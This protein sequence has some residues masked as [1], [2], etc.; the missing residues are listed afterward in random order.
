MSVAIA[1]LVYVASFYLIRLFY[2]VSLHHLD[3]YIGAMLFVIPGFPFITSGLDISKLD[4]RSGLERMAYAIMI[5]VVATAVGWVM[6]L[7]L[8]LH[9][10]NF[11]NLGLTPVVLTLL[12]LLASFCG[13]FG[14]SIMFNSKISMATIAG[15]SGAIANTL[16]LSLVDW[17]NVPPAVAAFIGAFVAGMLASIIRRKIGFPRIAI[18]VPSIVI[19][20]PG[21]YMYRAMFNLGLTSLNAGALW[22]VQ[23]LMIVICLP[24]G[25][26]AARILM[27][28]DWRHAG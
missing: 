17:S 27:D 20:V 16:R 23:A 12:R 13:V 24:L 5:I 25:L 11:E 14:F 15:I 1:C 2:P 18:T 22:M 6:A 21:L 10:Q 19:M 4:M 26:I 7:L 9:P 3:G 8:N 28:K